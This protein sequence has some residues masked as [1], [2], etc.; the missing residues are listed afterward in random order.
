[1]RLISQIEASPCFSFYINRIL[2]CALIFPSSYIDMD[3]FQKGV[4]ISINEV[5]LRTSKGAFF[6]ARAVGGSRENKWMLSI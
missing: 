4:N 3:Y 6:G 1:M 2:N 5:S